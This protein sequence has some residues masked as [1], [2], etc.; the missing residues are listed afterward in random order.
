MDFD[1]GERPDE[2]RQN[3]RQQREAGLMHP[4]PHAVQQDSVE[5]WIAEEDFDGALRGWITAENGINLLLDRS[6]HGA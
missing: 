6:E 3:P 5:A 2:L 4:V 1:S